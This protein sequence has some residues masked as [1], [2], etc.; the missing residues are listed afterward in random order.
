MHSAER[1]C[2]TLRTTSEENKVLARR[3]GEA[4][5]ARQFDVLNKLVAPDFVRHEDGKFA[6]MW[7]TW[8]NMAALSQLGHI[9]A[10]PAKNG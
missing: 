2:S 6:E 1:K 5:N 3:F 4:I 7:V 9:P 8:D 10:P